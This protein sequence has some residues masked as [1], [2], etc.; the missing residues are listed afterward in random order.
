M[1]KLLSGSTLRRGGSGEF[2][3]LAGAQ[4]QLP[5]TETTATGFT[6]VTDSLRR[7]S[8]R[9]SLGFIEFKDS[10]MWSNTPGGR[11]TILE[12]GTTDVS[13]S[14]Q[15]GNLV[16]EGGVGIGRN[17]FV[18]DDINVNDIVFGQ[19]IE[20]KNNIVITG[21]TIEIPEEEASSGQQNIVLGLNALEGLE[22]A[23]RNIAIGSYAL[24]SGTGVSNSI[25]IGDSALKNIGSTQT[26]EIGTITDVTLTPSAAIIFITNAAPAEVTTNDEH[27]FVTGERIYIIGVDGLTTSSFVNPFHIVNGTSFFINTL[28]T[29]TFELYHDIGLTNPVDTSLASVYEENGT[30][31][32]PVK[33]TV[34]SHLATTATFIQITNV[35]GTIELNGNQYYTRVIDS[36][37]LALYQDTILSEAVDG[38]EMTAYIS[39]GTI[40]RILLKTNNI[41]IGNDTGK[42]LIDGRRNFFIGDESGKN[43]TT[44]S[45]NFFIGHQ[46]GNNMTTGS[47]NISIGGD[48]I[49]DGKDNQVN[50]GSVFY[51]DGDGYATLNAETTIGLG[52]DSTGTNSGALTVIGGAGIVGN[53]YVGG[54]INVLSTDTSTFVGLIDGT[55]TTATNLA[56]GTTGSIP[57]QTVDGNT[58]FIDIG[59]NDTILV[60]NGTTA[61]WESISALTPETSTNALKIFVDNVVSSTNYYITL[62]EFT[63]DYNTL[64]NEVSLTFDT[65]DNKLSTPLLNVTS[66]ETSTSTVTSQAL[67]VEGGVGIKGN[68][69]VV[70]SVY[71]AEGIVDE[72]NLLYTPRT[73]VSATAPV[74]PRIGDYWVRSTNGVLYLYIKDGVDKFWLQVTL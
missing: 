33:L 3:D 57:Y 69:F 2:I 12:T 66:T 13:I 4:P 44:G 32:V 59:A 39:S 25:A 51:F 11:I 49:V 72:N 36:S 26:I 67:I 21:N 16:I 38:S 18:N 20:D 53:L 61:T 74:N 10:E 9:S 54:V 6:V 62:N 55:I 34:P 29:T 65:T 24:N 31:I 63:E 15:T 28:T 68:N 19:I 71:S 8:Y 37:T 64:T 47:G 14:P 73:T 5:P 1:P 52:S 46:V 41:A 35:S 56:G 40:S 70:G 42:N 60:S 7:T 27:G 23:Y 50:I 43:L 58:A 22:T 48:N 17:L 45:N 30:A